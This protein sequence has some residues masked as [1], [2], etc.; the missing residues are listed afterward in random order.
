MLDHL[1]DPQNFGAICRSA[2]ALGVSAIVIPKDRSVIVSSGVYHASV[3]AVETI[4]IARVTNLAQSI[5]KLKDHSYWII[6]SAAGKNFPPPWEGPDFK[7]VVLLVGG[8]LEG[9][10]PALEKLC[11]WR[12][13]IPMMGRVQSLNVS[14]ACALLIHEIRR[15]MGSG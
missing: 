14:V 12:T 6:G 2:D 10:H 15:R 4:P 9:I 8:E 1:Q 5:R 3:G 13:E 11:D 7:R